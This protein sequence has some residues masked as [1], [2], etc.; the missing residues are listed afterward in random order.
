[1]EEKETATE[2]IAPTIAPEE[3]LEA[4]MAQLEEEKENYRKAYL[5]S[6]S[7]KPEP[8][9]EEEDDKINR[10]VTEA[11]ANSKLAEIA[12]EQDEIIKKAL[13]ENKELKAAQLG[14]KKEPVAGMGAHSESIPVRDT[15]ITSEQ[16]ANF[17]ARGWTDQDIERYKQNLRKKL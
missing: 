10:K 7:K 2:T 4:K 15:S 1:M 6:E 5:K 13:K 3:D 16:M 11:I 17:K 9:D 14:I 12:R 8:V